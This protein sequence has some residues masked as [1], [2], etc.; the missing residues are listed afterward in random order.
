MSR[1]IIQQ[2]ASAL[3]TVRK[4]LRRGSEHGTLRF[5]NLPG[6][7]TRTITNPKIYAERGHIATVKDRKSGRKVRIG[8]HTIVDM[9]ST[10][11]WCSADQHAERHLIFPT[12]LQ[13]VDYLAY[14]NPMFR[15]DLSRESVWH[16]SDMDVDG[17]TVDR[18]TYTWNDWDTTSYDMTVDG[19]PIRFCIREIID[20]VTS[21]VVPLGISVETFHTGFY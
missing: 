3:A 20:P 19:V 16:V 13:V 4:F 8:N 6:T 14:R 21:F 5:R 10:A 12:Q 11:M 15:R 1:F 9:N 7:G 17:Y 2:P 18:Q